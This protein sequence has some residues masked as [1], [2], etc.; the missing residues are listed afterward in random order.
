MYI[1]IYSIAYSCDWTEANVS[2]VRHVQ[3]HMITTTVREGRALEMWLHANQS[4]P[5]HGPRPEAKYL[6]C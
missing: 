4:E 5:M 1:Y 2:S 3:D 6:L